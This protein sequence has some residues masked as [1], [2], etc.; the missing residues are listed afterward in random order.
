M[1]VT[2][3]PEQLVAFLRDGFVDVVLEELA[4]AVPAAFESPGA[5]EVP[6]RVDAALRRALALGL[7][8]GWDIYRYIEYRLRLGDDFE[9]RPEYQEIARVLA[10]TQVD[11]GARMDWLDSYY[12]HVLNPS[13]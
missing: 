1:E 6:A 11:G 12:E 4:A 9:S 3:R 7:A 5:A 2:I 8:D 13:A 10:S